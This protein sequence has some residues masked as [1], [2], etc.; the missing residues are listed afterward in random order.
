MIGAMAYY[1]THADPDHFQ[2]M[3]ANFGIFRL[4]ER[5]RKNERKEA[6]ARQALAVI[7]KLV[8]SHAL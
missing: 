8:D 3:N 2:P 4:N 5:V 1:I 7:R 6:M